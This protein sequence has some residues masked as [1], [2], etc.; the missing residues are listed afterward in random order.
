MRLGSSFRYKN[1]IRNSSHAEGCLAQVPC[2][3]VY[4]HEFECYKSQGHGDALWS[5]DGILG[6]VC[7]ILI[8]CNYSTA[9]SPFCL[10]PNGGSSWSLKIVL[11]DEMI[12]SDQWLMSTFI[13]TSFFSE[14]NSYSLPQWRPYFCVSWVD[15]LLKTWAPSSSRRS[16]FTRPLTKS[17]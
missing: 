10:Y 4:N 1:L 2:S 3:H 15:F 12:C 17:G 5:F 8:L 11:Y 16:W 7:Y 9:T 13:N 6:T 14:A